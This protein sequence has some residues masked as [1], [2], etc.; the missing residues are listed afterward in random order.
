MKAFQ[1]AP[2]QSPEDNEIFEPRG[3]EAA[4]PA[5]ADLRRSLWRC[6]PDDFRAFLEMAD[7]VGLQSAM[8][9][10]YDELAALSMRLPGRLWDRCLPGHEVFGDDLVF[11]GPG[12]SQLS[13]ERVIAAIALAIQPTKM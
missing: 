1:H 7:Q 2:L 6:F 3:L 11:R 12:G 5:L 8:A 13:A 10:T 4:V 9:L